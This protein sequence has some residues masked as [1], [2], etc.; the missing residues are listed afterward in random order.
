MCP[1]VPTFTCGL[2]RSNFSFAMSLPV[3]CA[4]VDGKLTRDSSLRFAH[5]F[6]GDVLGHFL[7]LAKVHGE[8]AASLGSRTELRRVAKHFRERHHRLD[9]VGAAQNLRA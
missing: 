6:L 7:V 8:R 9:D 2:L 3:S 4:S 1:I 5:N